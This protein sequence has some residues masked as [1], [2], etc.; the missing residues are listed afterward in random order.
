[1][2]SIMI[3]RNNVKIDFHSHI[4]PKCDHG[5]D[6]VETSLKQL[7][8]ARD[9]GVKVVCATPHFYPNECNVKEFLKLRSHCYKKLMNSRD[10]DS[11]KV[12]LGAEVLVCDNMDKMDDLQLLCIENTDYL[13]LEMPFYNWPESIFETVERLAERQ[14]FQI[15]IAH[16]DRYKSE[17]IECLIDMGVK[18]QLNAKALCRPFKRKHLLKWIDRG[19]VMALGSDIHGTK[20]GYKYFTKCCKKFG[21]K[22][23]CCNKIKGLS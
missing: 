14:D 6:S 3:Q 10:D 21:D 23:N 15:V 16:A 8:L 20:T 13:L 18:L 12:M 4:L 9:A 1:M 22:L 5:S 11:P 2:C 19:C 17:D 7:Q